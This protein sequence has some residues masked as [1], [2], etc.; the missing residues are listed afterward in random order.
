MSFESPS[1]VLMKMIILLGN[2][3]IE[4]NIDEKR[5]L[6]VQ[7]IALYRAKA[8]GSKGSSLQNSMYMERISIYYL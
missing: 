6:P 3:L 2:D 4:P 5:L 1:T 8:I 7:E